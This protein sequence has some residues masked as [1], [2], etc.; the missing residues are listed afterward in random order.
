M[1]QKKILIVDDDAAF[2]DSVEMILETKGF[3][4]LKALNAE[5]A[6]EALAVEKPDLILLD[7]NLPDKNG[8]EVLRTIK[9][10]NDLSCIS[11]IMVTG[12]MA[13]HVDKA[14]AEGADDCVFKP[15]DM[16]RF[17]EDINRLLK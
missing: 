6:Y 3:K 17:V 10:S 5:S 8:F 14:F 12:D 16:D 1:E 9:A 11:V 13:V 2:L 4:I 15:L 7:V